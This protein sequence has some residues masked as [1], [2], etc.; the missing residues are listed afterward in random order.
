MP[1]QSDDSGKPGAVG[2]MHFFMPCQIDFVKKQ[3]VSPI[4]EITR[5][6]KRH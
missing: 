5:Y 1:K 2:N 3:L 4:F 6:Q